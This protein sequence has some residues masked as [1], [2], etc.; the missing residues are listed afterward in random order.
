MRFNAS[1]S[2]G[3]FWLYRAVLP[4]GAGLIVFAGTN[5]F[6]TNTLAGQLGFL[7]W[8]AFLVVFPLSIMFSILR[9]RLWDIDVIIRKTLLYT[10]VTALL[11]L[12]YFG[13]VVSCSGCSAC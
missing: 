7:V 10:V 11:A 5:F 1:R 12:V 9:Y 4:L 3:R 8:S 13:S 2:V 6:E